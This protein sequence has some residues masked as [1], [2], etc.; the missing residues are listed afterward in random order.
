VDGQLAL[1]RQPAAGGLRLD[2]LIADSE[3]VIAGLAAAIYPALATVTETHDFLAAYATARGRPFSPGELQ[4]CW[5]AGVWTRAF[6]AKKQHA[7]EQPVISLTQ[8][9]AHETP[10]PGWNALSRRG[11]RVLTDL[12]T[13]PGGMGETRR[14]TGDS[15]RLG[16]LV[17]GTQRLSGDQQDARRFA[18]NPATTVRDL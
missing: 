6:D 7:A 14:A 17:S 4:R 11:A 18:H 2:S 12:L 1:A 3:A 16:A 8:D 5:A 9:E 13:K 10:S 15:S